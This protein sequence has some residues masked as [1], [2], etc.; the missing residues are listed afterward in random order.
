MVYNGAGCVYICVIG[1]LCEARFAQFPCD[2]WIRLFENPK[3]AAEHKRDKSADT[4]SVVRSDHRIF[5]Y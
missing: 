2:S 3:G 5:I 1:T 4:P